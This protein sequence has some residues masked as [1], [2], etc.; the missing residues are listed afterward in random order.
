MKLDIKDIKSHMFF[1]PDINEH[2]SLCTEP[3]YGEDRKF[4]RKFKM[5]KE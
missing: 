4:F 3:I 5:F 1:E 2:T